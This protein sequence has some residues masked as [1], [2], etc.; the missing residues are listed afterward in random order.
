MAIL[1]WI[2]PIFEWLEV[3]TKHIRLAM[4]RISRIDGCQNLRYRDIWQH[5]LGCISLETPLFAHP[6]AH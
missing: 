3:D 1:T 6:G 2:H 5:C 4:L